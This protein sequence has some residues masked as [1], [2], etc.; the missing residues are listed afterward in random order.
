MGKAQD[1]KKIN[2]KQEFVQKGLCSQS[3]EGFRSKDILA[4]V[5]FQIM[6]LIR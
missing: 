1:L 4:L 2:H 6:S 3:N 5:D